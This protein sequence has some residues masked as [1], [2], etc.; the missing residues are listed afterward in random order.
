KLW[1][2]APGDFALLE[3]ATS[4]F[5]AR[6]PNAPAAREFQARLRQL[7]ARRTRRRALGVTAAVVAA[8][9]GLWTYDAV[10]EGPARRVAEANGEAPVAARRHWQRYQAW[11]PTRHLFRPAAREAER[12]RLAELDARIHEQSRADRLAEL[13]H[14]AAD[15][16]ADLDVVHAS[17]R[18]FRAD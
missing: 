13:R 12:L 17:F 5:A 8:V 2:V 14:A 1:E 16:D 11:H 15:P 4:G 18:R 7:R 9:L 6:Y 3:R 10:A